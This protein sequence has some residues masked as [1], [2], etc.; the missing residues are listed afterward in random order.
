MFTKPDRAVDRVFLHCSASDHAH[1]D[2]IATMRKWH[3]EDRG[4]SD[5]G[6]HFFIRKDGTVEDGR[7]LE[8]TPAAQGGNNR[9]TIAICLHGLALENFTEAQ[10]TAVAELCSSITAAY[11]GMITF[12]GHCEVSSK[13]CPVFPYKAVLGLDSHGEMVFEK[14]S[15]PDGITPPDQSPPTDRTP[16]RPVLR[17]SD[18][19]S[20]VEILQRLL[21]T[22][23]HDIA[24]D[25]IF[26][27]GT[28][29]AVRAFQLTHGLVADA[30]VGPATW[31]ALQA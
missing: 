1:H 19:S 20:D 4:W 25:G 14:T 17:I 30:I 11:Q 2:N 5:V 16:P 13:A 29:A 6:Y 8:N 9:G 22:A 7:P 28:A 24:A 31:K 18:R 12:H 26:G 27:Q 23:G 15:R 3:V 21:I 10:Y